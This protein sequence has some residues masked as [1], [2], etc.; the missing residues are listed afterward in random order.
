MSIYYWTNYADADWLASRGTFFH[1]L[2]FVSQ[3]RN[4]PR[5]SL[6]AL[7]RS[8]IALAAVIE[9]FCQLQKLITIRFNK[10]QWNTTR[11]FEWPMRF[12]DIKQRKLEINNES[13]TGW[14]WPISIQ[15]QSVIEFSTQKHSEYF[16][17]IEMIRYSLKLEN[18]LTQIRSY[19][20]TLCGMQSNRREQTLKKKKL[21]LHSYEILVLIP[22]LLT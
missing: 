4:I 13:T 9:S 22:S 17:Y 12:F 19:L 14:V 18:T 1:L 16:V 8:F 10:M 7:V 2:S 15:V 11:R 6:A 5:L 3:M 20:L 21:L